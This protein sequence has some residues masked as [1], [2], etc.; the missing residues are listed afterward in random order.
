MDKT[1]GC[2]SVNAARSGGTLDAHIQ[3][4]WAHAFTMACGG[5]DEHLPVSRTSR[6]L[7][8]LPSS[9]TITLVSKN[10]TYFR[11]HLVVGFLRDEIHLELLKE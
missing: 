8:I 4:W 1:T 10:M 7:N 5:I 9:S 3:W 11:D 2:A 6:W